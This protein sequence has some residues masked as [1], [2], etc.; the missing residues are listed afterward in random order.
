MNEQDT[1]F[2]SK[3]FSDTGFRSAYEFG[4]LDLSKES[5]NEDGE[6]IYETDKWFLCILKDS[7]FDDYRILKLKPYKFKFEN[8]WNFGWENKDG[9]LFSNLA[10]PAFEYDN[11][12][13]VRFRECSE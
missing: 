5:P 2:L 11:L 4:N 8:A 7:R 6:I 3:I 10:F 13:V 9:N 1:V 12:V